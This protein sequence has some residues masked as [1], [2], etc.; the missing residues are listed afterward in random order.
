ME[1]PLRKFI[2]GPV[3]ND[4]NGTDCPGKKALVLTSKCFGIP[5]ADT[6]NNLEIKRRTL[7]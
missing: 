3:V 4:N 5:I 7:L 1:T 2:A 6:I